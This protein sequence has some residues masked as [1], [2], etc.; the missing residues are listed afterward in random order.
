MEVG[1][2]VQVNPDSK[3]VWLRGVFVQVTD[4][5][6]DGLVLGFT[7]VLTDKHT[8]PGRAY[9]LLERHEYSMIGMAAW[10]KA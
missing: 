6:E 8:E 7:L 1:V 5:R 3:H 10:V 4:V 9:I 2:V